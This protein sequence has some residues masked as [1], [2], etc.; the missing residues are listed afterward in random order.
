[1]SL[2]LVPL[3]EYGAGFQAVSAAV[4]ALTAASLRRLAVPI[5]SKR[6]ATYSVAPSGERA[7]L[8]TPL[9]ALLAYLQSAAQ[10][11]RPAPLEALSAARFWRANPPR[12]KNKPPT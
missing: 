6:P 9:T 7:S 2:T 3:A 4:E 8:S 10:P 12:L 1:M 11:D 5:R